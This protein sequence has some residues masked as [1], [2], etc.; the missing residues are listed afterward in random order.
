MSLGEGECDDPLDGYAD[1]HFILSRF[2]FHLNTS[3]L[4][5]DFVKP[6]ISTLRTLIER[7]LT[8][9]TGSEKIVPR[10]GKVTQKTTSFTTSAPSLFRARLL[11][12]LQL[13]LGF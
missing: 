3:S 8:A 5:P 9:C 13:L 12:A 1:E 10:P 2:T 6:T 11:P 7:A 4:L